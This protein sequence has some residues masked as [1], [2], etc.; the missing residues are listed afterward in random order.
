MKNLFERVVCA[1]LNRPV[2]AQIQV[3]QAFV[4]RRGQLMDDTDWIQ[5]F[6]QHTK[7]NNIEDTTDEDLQTFLDYVAEQ[8]QTQHAVLCAQRAINKIRRFY[9]ARTRRGQRNPIHWDAVQRVKEMRDEQGMSYREIAE[10]L[11]KDVRQIHR[12]YTYAQKPFE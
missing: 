8:Y 12:W 6:C 4:K 11:G 3:Y 2:H 7:V 9:R 1:I 5:L 10:K